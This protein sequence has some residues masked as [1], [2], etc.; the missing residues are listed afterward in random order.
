VPTRFE[1]GQVVIRASPGRRRVVVRASD[2][3]ETKNQENVH[4]I[5]PNTATLERTVVVHAG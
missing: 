2:H 3:Q 1:D 4:R 5:R